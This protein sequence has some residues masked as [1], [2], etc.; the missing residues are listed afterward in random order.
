MLT[1]LADP[2]PTVALILLQR[3]NFDVPTPEWCTGDG[4][5]RA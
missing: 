4:P 2:K 1:P 5:I 3:S